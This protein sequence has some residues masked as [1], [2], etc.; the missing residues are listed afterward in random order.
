MVA[1]GRADDPDKLE[2]IARGDAVV[3]LAGINRAD[4]AEVRGRQRRSR[5]DVAR[6]VAPPTSRR[7]VYANSIQAAD[8]TTPYGRGKLAAPTCSLTSPRAEGALVD[9]RLPNLFGEH[10]RP[11]YNSF[12]ASFATPLARRR[13]S[14][15]G[16]RTAI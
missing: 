5:E 14:R 9:V 2:M 11:G 8:P 10:G 7:V 4:D 16:R 6:A 15:Q 1:V 12:V 3:H 13:R